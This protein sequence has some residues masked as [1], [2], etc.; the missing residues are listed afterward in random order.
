V[1]PGA[2]HGVY[3]LLTLAR[4]RR[5]VQAIEATYKLDLRALPPTV[6]GMVM[7]SARVR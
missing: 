5:G 4:R 2:A 1:K 7:S 6:R 3:V